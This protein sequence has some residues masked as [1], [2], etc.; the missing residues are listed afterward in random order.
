MN[1]NKKLYLIS[2]FFAPLG[3]AD[4]VN[5]TYMTKYLTELGWNVDV[6]SCANPHGFMQS[7]VTDYSLMDIIPP[8]VKLHQINSTYWGP[9]GGIASLLGLM[10]DPFVNWYRPVM[11]MA[12][13]I[14]SEKG[15][16]YTIV[17]PF[18]NAKIGFDIS[19]RQKMPLI[20]DFRD[21]IF[22]LPKEIVRSCV[23]I[24]ASTEHSLEDMR[25]YYGLRSEIGLT[26]YNGFSVEYPLEAKKYEKAEG[27]KIVYA[28]LINLDQDPVMLA[29]ALKMMEQKHPETRMKV[30]IDYYGPPNYYTRFLLKKQ[31]ADNICYQG[32]LP[33]KEVL[34]KIACADISYS[35]LRLNNNRYRIPSKVF[36]YIAMEIP[37]LGTGPDGALKE[38]ICNNKIGK[39]S[40]ANDI[41]GQAEDIYYLLNNHEARLE[42]IENIRKIKSKF[43]MKNQVKK[44][45]DYMES[46]IM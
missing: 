39:F 20:I 42:M 46:F 44:L 37:I 12:D 1:K 29:R 24:I 27:L 23:T 22:N 28:G 26:I 32:F 7:F 13:S 19:Q 30:L 31:L 5:R 17:P 3:R 18:T 11:R 2:Y 21:N 45:S 4:G 15:V 25:K 43:A 6:I 36:Q 41:E 8:Q 35:S 16:I 10:E 14:F 34:K 40:L 9:F 33:F 38:F